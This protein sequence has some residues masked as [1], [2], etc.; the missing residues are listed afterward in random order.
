MRAEE[1]ETTPERDREDDPH[2]RSRRTSRRPPSR[3]RPIPIPTGSRNRRRRIPSPSRAARADG[4]GKAAPRC[5]QERQKGAVGC[6][7]EENDLKAAKQDSERA[8]PRGSEGGSPKARC[9]EGHRD[10]RRGDDR[11]RAAAGGCPSGHRGALEDGQGPADTRRRQKRAS[12]AL[13]KHRRSTTRRRRPHHAAPGGP[14]NTDDGWY[15]ATAARAKS[16]SSTSPRRSLALLKPEPSTAF[17]AVAPS[18]PSMS[19]LDHRSSASSH[20][21]HASTS[22]LRRRLMHPPLAS[23]LPSEVLDRVGHIDSVR[24]PARPP[25]ARRLAGSRPAPRT[26]LPPC[27]R[28]PPAPRRSASPRRRRTLSEHHLSRVS[29]QSTAPAFEPAAWRSSRSPRFGRISSRAGR[30]GLA[31][32]RTRP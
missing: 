25:L 12:A 28:G 27:P 30:A 7:A 9:V 5:P 2:I 32:A 15:V 14:L 26:A 20:G 21:R 10:R 23:L 3:R 11:G 29:P 13:G 19:G 31:T 18:R 4:N 16:T 1:P 24:G 6:S 17:A 22:E 8:W